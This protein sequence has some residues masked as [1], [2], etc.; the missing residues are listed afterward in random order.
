MHKEPAISIIPRC[1]KKQQKKKKHSYIETLL[2]KTVRMN[3]NILFTQFVPQPKSKETL[4]MLI[5]VSWRKYLFQND[6]NLISPI[7]LQ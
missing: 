1:K 7:N 4:P 2:P 3:K 5:N 6:P